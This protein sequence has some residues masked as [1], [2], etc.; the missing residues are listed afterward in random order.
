[1]ELKIYIREW[2]GIDLT[3]LP[4]A[5]NVKDAPAGAEVYAEFY[6]ALNA[7]Q[8]EI[9]PSWV[10]AKR[11]L[12]VAI[13][14]LFEDF[15]Q[16]HGREPAILAVGAGRAYA[17]GVWLD[18]QR[19]V[20]LNDWQ[21]DSLEYAKTHWPDAKTLIGDAR[22]LDAARKFDFITLMGMDYTMTLEEFSGVLAGCANMLAEHG[23]I[24]MY[25][26]SV[27]SFRQM[28]VVPAKHMLGTYR[29]TPHLFWGY[30]RTPGAF[31]R[32]A[33]AAGLKVNMSYTPESGQ[34]TLRPSM[35]D[36]VPPWREN[37]LIQVL[38][39]R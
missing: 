1:M 3:R 30:W 10:A 13:E 17:E 29:K 21:D 23:A 14:T 39:R 16:Q 18:H 8:G 7:G 2:H 37:N 31:V 32:A 28:A 20:T 38:V 19:D 6:A 4:A 36:R 24:I 15:R 5:A 26:A 12:G 22:Q 9:S 34:L 35:L 27:L 11:I 25:C 33:A